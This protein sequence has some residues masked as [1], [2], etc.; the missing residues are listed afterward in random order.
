MN[1]VQAL[2][3]AVQKAEAAHIQGAIVDAA[4]TALE[5]ARVIATC[6]EDL[7][8]AIEKRNVQALEAAIKKARLTG[9]DEETL[10]KATKA[11]MALKAAKA[12]AMATEELRTAID[13]NTVHAL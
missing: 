7:R 4:R 3:L 12:K 6:T 11:F 9:V 2:Q 10:D 5:A 13:K 1:T 8:V